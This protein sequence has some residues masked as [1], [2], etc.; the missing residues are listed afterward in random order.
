MTDADKI[1]QLSELVSELREENRHLKKCRMTQAEIAHR[2]W[3]RMTAQDRRSNALQARVD[4]LQAWK[5]AREAEQTP[6]AQ[7]ERIF[8]N[9]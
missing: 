4:F 2:D 5:D 9:D 7:A 3:V 8:K 6:E 1:A